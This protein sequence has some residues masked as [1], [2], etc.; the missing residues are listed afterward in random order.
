MPITIFF[1][2]AREDEALL[3]K[4]KTHLRPLQR[5][6][7]I[8]VRY[9]RDVRAGAEWEHGI[10]TNLNATQIVLLL[11][12]PDFL[13]SEYCYSMEMQRV[14]ERHESG[15][16]CVIPIVLRPVSWEDTP[17]QHLQ[18]LPR[19]GI[20]VISKQWENRDAAWV[21][22]VEEIRV[23]IATLTKTKLVQQTI[24]SERIWYVPYRRNPFF[25]GREG[26]LQQLRDR[27]TAT[28]T[29]ALSQSQAISG[30]GGIGKTQIALEYAYR[31]R[32]AYRTIL[33]L[34]AA[35]EGTLQ[36]DFAKVAPLLG[37]RVSTN[38]D[39]QEV[40]EAVKSWLREQYDWLLILDNADDLLK[41]RLFLPEE[42]ILNGHVLL[43]TRAQ[44]VGELAYKVE[45]EQM[46]QQDG[47]LLLLRRAKYLIPGATL[48]QANL[49]ARAK[50]ITIVKELGGLP[51]ALDQA[52]A[53]IEETGC[54]LA[55]YL[56]LYH[57][58][59]QELLQRRSIL[60]SGHPEPVAT[61]WSLS[62][63]L[64]ERANPLTA[65]ILRLCSFL[66]PDAIPEFI[67]TVKG[68]E[69]NPEL[70]PVAVDIFALN[71]AIEEL[72][73]FSLVKR[74]ADVGLL[75][76]HRLVQ[77]V[78]KDSMEE[79]IQQQW[80]ARAVR[81]VNAVFPEER[82]QPIQTLLP[83]ALICAESIEK[84]SLTFL[85]A[86]RLL[87]RTAIYL[88]DEARYTEAEPLYKRALAIREQ[89]LGSEHPDTA[90]VLDN[91]A[92][93]YRDQGKYTEAELLYQRALVIREQILGPEHLYTS[94]TLNNLARLY[95][96]QGR[97]AE[98]EPL[99]QRALAIREQILSPEHPDTATILHNQGDLYRDQ[100]KYPE[101]ES[102]YQRA[103]AI[104]ESK[105]GSEH[106]DTAFTLNNLG[107]LYRDQRKYT[108]AEPLYNRALSI[109]ESKLGPE[110]P[111]TATTI[112]NLAKL[113]QEQGKY[114]EAE[115]LYLRA[116]TIRKQMQGHNHP[117]TAISLDNLARL[118]RDQNK[119]AEAEPLYKQALAIYTRA[120]NANH[121]YIAITLYN[122]ANLYCDQSKFTEAEPLYK[123]ALAIYERTS[124]PNHPYTAA[125][126]R[127][128]ANL[129]YK[130][131]KFAEAE[132]LYQRALEIDER[133]YG[134]EHP[135][136]ATDLENYATLLQAM[137][138]D[139]EAAVLLDRAKA[140]RTAIN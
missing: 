90:S 27:F 127:S 128:L 71:Q 29:I 121:P 3:K 92:G 130:Q 4:L 41:V 98:A 68:G 106:P 70:T 132:P 5:Q 81:A 54:S 15:N 33:W 101:A 125:T 44:A 66:A 49:K 9:D 64:V 93:V 37:V 40:V 26:L 1:C 136:V 56:D 51:L 89:V 72:R 57:I 8:D 88:Q 135:E 2:Y 16:A 120:L 131:A 6:G 63:Q 10:K 91:L 62:F 83:Q 42:Y 105:L 114:A 84:Y 24:P 55:T 28:N 74:N 20:P 86:A 52:G 12:S 122:L 25:T 60:H 36:E 80:A 116:L 111:Y 113:Y 69:A 134:S 123:Q 59:R 19:N 133:A 94:I 85:E 23:V 38:Q 17:F 109:R 129:Y 7:L 35:S 46:N 39:R 58:R 126:L 102:L 34:T 77:A 75:S 32:Q 110:H 82:W 30:L 97:F 124:G 104:R 103:L 119:Y 140:M 45:V 76:M 108:E 43:T 99:Y 79:S 73:K 48:K 18:V 107:R 96:D 67:L 115:P 22:V 100:G 117:N 21:H 61:T 95:R 31:Y 118:Y 139:H 50:A 14:M 11:V 47:A 78:L 112:H 65:D 137:Q 13:A 138:R 53:Y 87:D